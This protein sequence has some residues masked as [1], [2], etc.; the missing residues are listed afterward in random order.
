MAYNRLPKFRQAMNFTIC[1]FIVLLYSNFLLLYFE[2]ISEIKF[3]SLQQQQK[4][5]HSKA[6][7]MMNLQMFKM[8][9][10][11]VWIY[12]QRTVKMNWII[13]QL[14]Q[15]FTNEFL[16]FSLNLVTSFSYQRFNEILLHSLLERSK[17][18]EMFC[19]ICGASFRARRIWL[20]MLPLRFSYQKFHD[21][22]SC[23]FVTMRNKITIWSS[24]PM[25]SQL[26][27][28]FIS[29]EIPLRFVLLF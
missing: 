7:Q 24:S 21:K 12:G 5:T 2:A 6:H 10:L 1:C 11:F 8:K 18:K 19:R 20:M 15:N 29:G 23:N 27:V 9:N 14:M 16:F 4:C 25:D 17:A 3:L 28:A 22:N 13:C 26:S